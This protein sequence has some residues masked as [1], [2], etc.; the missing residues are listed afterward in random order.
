VHN[1]IMLDAVKDAAKRVM[2]KDSSDDALECVKKVHTSLQKYRDQFAREWREFERAYYGAIWDNTSKYKPFEN[3]VFEII[4]GEVPILTDSMPSTV[5]N[6][7]DEEYVEQVKTLGKAIK[8]V[9]KDQ[10]LQIRLPTVIRNSLK[11]APG[12]IYVYN[13]CNANNGDGQIKYE[14][15]NY[16]SVYLDGSKQFIEE[17]EKARI[18][19]PRSRDW[20]Y[21][22]YPS[23]KKEI[24]NLKQ[25]VDM[26][27]LSDDQRGRESYDI[28][29][30]PRPKTPI[31][32]QDEDSFTLVQT[33]KKDYSIEKIP[34]EDTA[35]ELAKEDEALKEGSA[36]DVSK[37]QDHAMHMQDHFM[38]RGELAT[39]LGAA[40]DSPFE[41]IE[42]IVEQ[43][44]EQTPDAAEEFSLLLLRVKI[45]DDHIEAHKLL[46]RENPE[47]GR[48]KYPNGWRLIETVQNKIF[49]DGPL[50]DDHGEIPLVPFYCYKDET[51]Y[52]FGEIK[53]IIDS[54]RMKAVMQFKEYKGLQKVA[55]PSV[56][57]GEGTGL[58]E[59]DITN[60]DGAV[61]VIPDDAFNLLD[62]M[63]P[64]NT[65]PQVTGFQNDRVDNMKSISGMVEVTQGKMPSPNAAAITVEKTQ[66]QAIGRIRLK[67]RQNQHYSMRR[68]GKLTAACIIQYWT[69]EKVLKLEKEGDQMVPFIYNPLEMQDLEYEV[70]IS[71]GSM[72]GV[73]KDAY[74]QFLFNLMA[75]GQIN[76]EQFSAMA[77]D[78]LPKMDKLTELVSQDQ[79]IQ[80]HLQEL[81]M[82]NLMLRAQFQPQSL[83][84]DE[85]KLVQEFQAQQ[86][87][88]N[89]VQPVQQ[90]NI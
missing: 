74:N 34:V 68:L 72:A 21:L 49:Y 80:E 71:P 19:L 90:G 88:D 4:E 58:T 5:V 13:D 75:G 65:N 42:Q 69:S 78:T 37:W 22:N 76:L 40:P 43:L 52:G 66:Q 67:D 61:Y 18:E 46:Q 82:Q 17:S 44:A 47:N 25:D 6:T 31:L 26:N 84:E 36:P 24:K 3:R 81:Q 60:E 73:D 59:N 79:Q 10:S 39:Q 87:G 86:S 64:G 2:K 50:K 85:I 51:I 27:A 11:S 1:I 38:R 23:K 9:Q 41:E 77:E 45:L 16:K 33:Y 63:Q 20:L 55:N 54:A 8:W 7:T 53:N 57:V 15:L 89:T 83:S 62:H 14:I 48:L 29:G 28:G 12:Y 35:E 30:R 32:Y 70:D 56:K